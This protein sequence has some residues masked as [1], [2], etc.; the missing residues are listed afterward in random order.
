MWRT[1]SCAIAHTFPN[2]GNAV[3][4]FV[5]QTPGDRPTI[6][7]GARLQEK[8][9]AFRT[10][11]CRVRAPGDACLASPRRAR[12]PPYIGTCDVPTIPDG[13][14]RNPMLNPMV[15]GGVFTRAPKTRP[16]S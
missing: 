15:P 13:M 4:E 9:T 12:V 10:P 7:A 16:F 1:H 5:G 3:Q 11:A 2:I 6:N 8:Y 14:S